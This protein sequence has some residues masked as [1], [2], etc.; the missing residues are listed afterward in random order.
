MC[1]CEREREREREIGFISNSYDNMNSLTCSQA[2][3]WFSKS[4]R[5][6]TKQVAEHKV[7]GRVEHGAVPSLSVTGTQL[8]CFPVLLAVTQATSAETVH[9]QTSTPTTLPPPPIGERER[10][11][12]GLPD[13]LFVSNMQILVMTII[14][15][16]VS[17]KTN[18]MKCN[19]KVTKSVFLS[20][21]ETTNNNIRN[22]NNK[23]DNCPFIPTPTKLT[24]I[25]CYFSSDTESCHLQRGQDTSPI[26]VQW[27]LEEIQ[28]CISVTP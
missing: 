25:F 14:F 11:G 17:D 13:F 7:Q 4:Q 21:L 8:L 10:G 1:V 20:T 16:H 22:N 23:K 28:R 5:E 15:N 19:G 26:S 27:R 3:A 6:E 2:S 12:W 18:N 9:F 24:N